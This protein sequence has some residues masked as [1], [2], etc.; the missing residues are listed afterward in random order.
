MY[1]HYIVINSEKPISPWAVVSPVTLNTDMFAAPQGLAAPRL[2]IVSRT[3]LR[4][5]WEAPDV[6][7]GQIVA[8]NLY[9]DDEMIDI[10]MITAGSY[11]I[12]DLQPFQIYKVQVS[13]FF[14]NL[15]TCK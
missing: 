12:S 14:K 10:G 2:T 11:V 9:L 1:H 15:L 5:M 7:N 6:A 3:A 4:V 8:Y 13:T